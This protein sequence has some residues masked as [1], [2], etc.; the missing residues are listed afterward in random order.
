[1]TDNS[2]LC[3][4]EYWNS[5]PP[6]NRILPRAGGVH[7]SKI[8]NF[9]VREGSTAQESHSSTRRSSPPP[10]NRAI[11]R[12]GMVHRPRIVQFHARVWYNAQESHISTRW[13]LNE[14]KNNKNA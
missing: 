12:A 1:M 3:L 11:P 6:R 10:R 9:H 14:S 13:K 7:H 5:P 4:S 8:T 2:K